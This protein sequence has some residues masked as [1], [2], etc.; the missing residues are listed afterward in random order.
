MQPAKQLEP[1]KSYR[2][3]IIYTW[4]DESLLKPPTRK[5]LVDAVPFGIPKFGA[6]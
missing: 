1:K 6:L 3:L 5:P 2:T 4:N